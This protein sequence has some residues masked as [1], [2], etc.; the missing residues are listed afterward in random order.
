MSQEPRKIEAKVN[1]EHERWRPRA[2]QAI[3]RQRALSAAKIRQHFLECDVL[4]IETPILMPYGSVDPSLH[5]FVAMP[6]DRALEARERF[7]QTSPE[8]AMKRLLAA[9]SGDIYQ[10]ARAF[11]AEEAGRHHLS[12]F[13]MIEWYRLGFDHHR[14]MDDVQALVRKVA[15]QLDFERVTYAR[16]FNDAFGFDPHLGSDRELLDATRA[17]GIEF[18]RAA[19]SRVDLLEALFA[20]ISHRE[21]LH[22]R[23][24]F[25]YDFPVEQAAYAQIVGDSPRYA[26]R[27]E[28]L[29]GGVELANGYHELTDWREQHERLVNENRIRAARNLLDVPADPAFL[30]A[31]QHGLPNCAGVAL[32]FDRLLLCC[33]DVEHISDV[34]AFCEI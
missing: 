12:E 11:R 22:D 3:L 7:L 6:H 23:A 34:V 31:L 15:P 33:N 30:A 5:S 13:T 18:G 26:E 16:L 24:L 2:S 19:A 20:E 28:L 8:F 9:G 4:E 1:D 10:F 25:I 32:G 14:L 27:F 17:C 21:R 29:V